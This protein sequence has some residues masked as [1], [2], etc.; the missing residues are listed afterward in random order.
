MD[1]KQRQ[2]IIDHLVSHISPYAIYIFGSYVR[3]TLRP[4][5]D[6]DIAFLSD[7][8]I[9]NMTTFNIAQKLASKLNIEVDLINLNEASTV[10]QAQIITTGENIYCTDETK[11]MYFEMSILKQ[12]AKLNEERHIIVKNIKESGSVYAD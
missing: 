11:R 9:D 3:Q 6:I 2:K 1:I 7:R 10:F 4:D 8:K 12:Y 5:S